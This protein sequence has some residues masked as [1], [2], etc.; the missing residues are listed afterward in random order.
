MGK[1]PPIPVKQEPERPTLLVEK[2]LTSLHTILECVMSPVA[3]EE[4]IWRTHYAVRAFLTAYDKLDSALSEEDDSFPFTVFNLPSL[5]DLPGM[6]KKHGPLRHLWEGGPKGE[7]YFR[8]S[9][10]FMKSGFN[11]S[12]WHAS[13]FSTLNETKSMGNILPGSKTAMEPPN[14]G[15]ALSARRLNIHK[16]KSVL[17]FQ[18]TWTNPTG[19]TPAT[20]VILV[21]SQDNTT[22]VYAVV[23]EYDMLVEINKDGQV[24]PIEK[25]GLHYYQFSHSYSEIDDL[26]YWKDI[27]SEVTDI[28]YGM[29]LP[30]MSKGTNNGHKA[31]ISSNWKSLGPS[32]ELAELVDSSSVDFG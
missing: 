1:V 9:K 20:P 8:V 10:P 21:N 6:I 14:S 3:T 24:E 22:K 4:V 17:E 13:L 15:D 25:F 7:G 23:G 27:C 26:I 18:D 11:Y 16:H 28:G 31:L 29:L 2:T 5:V 32:V 30:L 19:R 12:T